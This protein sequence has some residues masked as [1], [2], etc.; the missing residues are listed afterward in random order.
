MS[1]IPSKMKLLITQFLSEHFPNDQ[2]DVSQ[3]GNDFSVV[4]KH[5]EQPKLYFKVCGTGIHDVAIRND[6]FD[7]VSELFGLSAYNPESVAVVHSFI[8]S[9]NS[10][11][12]FNEVFQP[13]PTVDLSKYFTTFS[14]HDDVFKDIYDMDTKLKTPSKFSES[15]YA[16][17][18][19]FSFRFA[20]NN[21]LKC[22]P[23][24]ALFHNAH[25]GLS[26]GF[27]LDTQS[28]HLIQDTS[29]LYEEFFSINR[30]FDIHE[31]IDSFVLSFVD[32]LIVNF[33]DEG[34]ESMNAFS[35]ETATFSEKL[36]LLKMIS[37]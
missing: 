20:A 1:D 27:N 14:R 3:F 24:M 28:V 9:V 34:H 16:S 37:I 25:C 13:L 19:Q 18:I 15:K 29:Y 35:L 2:H 36:G 8:D 17:V 6:I 4:V 33:S 23:A 22:F 31:D 7:T 32:S 12:S 10:N 5:N 30:E 21:R 26:V 11:A